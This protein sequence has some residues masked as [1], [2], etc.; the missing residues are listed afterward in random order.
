MWIRSGPRVG[1]SISRMFYRDTEIVMVGVG[2]FRVGV[3]NC[4]VGMDG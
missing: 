3:P 1:V 2:A 4:T